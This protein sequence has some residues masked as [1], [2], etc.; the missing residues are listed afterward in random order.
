MAGPPEGRGEGRCPSGP[1]VVDKNFYCF[2][3]ILFR[4]Q[5]ERNR[6]FVNFDGLSY[7]SKLTPLSSGISGIS[8][9][10]DVAFVGE[11]LNCKSDLLHTERFISQEW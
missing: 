5:V 2:Q 3:I 8:P 9:Y 4:F 7:I 1:P 11:T 10:H 6:I